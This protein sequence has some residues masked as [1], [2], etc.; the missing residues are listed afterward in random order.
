MRRL[1]Q[2]LLNLKRFSQQSIASTDVPRILMPSFANRMARLFG[3]CPPTDTTMPAH[4]SRLAMSSTVSWLSSSKYSRSDSSKSVDTVSGLQLMMMAWCPSDRSVF[5]HDTQHQSNSTLLPMRYG[6]Q[7]RTTTPPPAG[8][9][10]GS[11]LRASLRDSGLN[12]S[13]LPSVSGSGITEVL[14]DRA[15]RCS[16]DATLEDPPVR[17]RRKTWSSPWP[18]RLTS[19][20]RPL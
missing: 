6:P 15:P 5:T 1:S 14:G 2:S 12:F 19:C 17:W 3:V 10:L 4:R 8:L 13:E 20:S 7:P 18:A 11:G 16:G 9:P